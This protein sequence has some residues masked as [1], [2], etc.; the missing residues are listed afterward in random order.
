MTL[1]ELLSI[2]D[3]NTNV[4]VNLTLYNR[5]FSMTGSVGYLLEN[6]DLRAKTVRKLC[7]SYSAYQTLDVFLEDE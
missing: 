5:T 7:G 1:G 4:T 2:T 6:E 3:T